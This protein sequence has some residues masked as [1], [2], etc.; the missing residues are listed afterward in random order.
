MPL[1]SMNN[2]PPPSVMAQGLV[3]GT[4]RGIDH[5]E[6]VDRDPTALDV[7]GGEEVNEVALIEISRGKLEAHGISPIRQNRLANPLSRGLT[8]EGTRGT[9]ATAVRP[10]STDS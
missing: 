8:G 4:H 3:E 7:F 5:A 1:P 2:V 6:Q 9:P 10:S